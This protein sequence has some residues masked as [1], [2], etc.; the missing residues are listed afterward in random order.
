MKISVVIITRNEEKRIADCIL[1]VEGCADEVIV[2]DSFSDDQTVSIAEGLGAK[3]IQKAF[4]GYGASKNTANEIAT[5]DYILSLDA[6][7]R[8]DCELCSELQKIKAS[9]NKKPAYRLNRLS[10]Y[11]GQWIRHGGWSSDKK[12]RFW[13][14]GIGHW[15]QSE[16]HERLILQKG[17]IPQ[18][19]PGNILH[20]SYA[21]VEEHCGKIERYAEKGAMEIRRSGKKPGSWRK[22]VSPAARWFR[23]YILKKG[24][25]DGKAGWQIARLTAYEVWLKYSKV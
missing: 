1:S 14:K 9:D 21:T 3:V 20:Y 24:F 7:E 17:I 11:C 15:N 4:A 22:I 2:L 8:L 6:D 16:V 5:G 13:K 19:L 10:N 12:V 18:D 23:D 25:L